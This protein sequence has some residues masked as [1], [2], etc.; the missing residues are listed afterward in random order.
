V[1]HIEGG[2]PH[3]L[4]KILNVR[5]SRVQAN[6][7]FNRMGSAPMRH[8]YSRLAFWAGSLVLVPKTSRK[9]RPDDFTEL[10]EKVSLDALQN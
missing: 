6:K 10:I 7:V 4:S 5:Y 8:G 2:L 1:Y 3:W 9:Y